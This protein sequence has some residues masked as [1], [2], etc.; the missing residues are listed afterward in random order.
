MNF[1]SPL[2]EYKINHRLEQQRYADDLTLIV[3]TERLRHDRGS[4]KKGSFSFSSNE[5]VEDEFSEQRE[6]LLFPGIDK[7]NDAQF[8]I[9]DMILFL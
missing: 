1:G 6:T 8:M 7:D 2:L 3:E 9:D 5:F 4:T